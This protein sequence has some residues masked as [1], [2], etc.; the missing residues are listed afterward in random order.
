MIQVNL[1]STRPLVRQWPDTGVASTIQYESLL[2]EALCYSHY[3]GCS[4]SRLHYYLG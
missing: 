4:K 1:L 2:V 3:A